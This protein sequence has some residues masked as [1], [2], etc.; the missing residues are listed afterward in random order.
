MF[1]QPYTTPEILDVTAVAIA[2][3]NEAGAT[4][5]KQ[6]EEDGKIKR[7]KSENFKIICTN[8]DN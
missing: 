5:R 1:D 3:A 4:A 6:I 2:K 8:P 7:V